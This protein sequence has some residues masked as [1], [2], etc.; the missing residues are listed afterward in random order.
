[1]IQIP[2]PAGLP[3]FEFSVVLDDRLWHLNFAYNFFIKSYTFCVAD[4]GQNPI[5]EG[6]PFQENI[7]LLSQYQNSSYDLPLGHLIYLS[8]TTSH[9]P[10]NLGL[11]GSLCY[12]GALS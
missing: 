3:S 2:L 5:L 8:E 12:T 10:D 1:M 4:S 7:P 6:I 11:S 9:S